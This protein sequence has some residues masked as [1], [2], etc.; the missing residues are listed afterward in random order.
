LSDRCKKLLAYPWDF[1]IDTTVGILQVSALQGKCRT[2][3][4]CFDSNP[5]EVLSIFTSVNQENDGN[6]LGLLFAAKLAGPIGKVSATLARAR[7]SLRA[8]PQNRRRACGRGVDMVF[9]FPDALV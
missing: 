8:R 7:K 2:R 5:G 4:G 3:I 1:V 9:H 6:T